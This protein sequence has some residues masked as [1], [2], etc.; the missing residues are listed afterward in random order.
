MIHPFISSF[1]QSSL[2]RL[3]T[4]FRFL[5]WKND[6][7]LTLHENMV[8]T[9]LPAP[10]ANF[11]NSRPIQMGFLPEVMVSSTTLPPFTECVVLATLWGQCLT[12]RRLALTFNITPNW[13][14]ISND[15][16][17]DNSVNSLQTRQF[18]TRHEFLATSLDKRIQLLA[19]S[20][21]DM[22]LT[23]IGDPMQAYTHILAHSAMI[24]LCSTIATTSL[25]VL[26]QQLKCLAYEQR[27]F[28]AASEVV[29]VVNVIST[30]GCFKAHPFLPY[31][32]SFAASF[33]L[34]H[35]RPPDLS[36]EPQDSTREIEELQES[37]RNLKEVNNLARELWEKLEMNGCII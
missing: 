9:R 6:L 18:W 27:A 21:S 22:S 20:D 19:G 33:L 12:H 17:N 3:L 10:E 31:P 37:L 15:L 32:L 36:I 30:L 25:Q 16:M 1:S 8:Q 13:I 2:A 23:N 4:S 34:T 26:E 11:Q 29:R 5:S 35:V 7:P 24:H 14:T 28:K